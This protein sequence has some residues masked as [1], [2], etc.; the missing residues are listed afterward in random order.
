MLDLARTLKSPKSATVMSS[1]Y[2][3]DVGSDYANVST[4]YTYMD[5]GSAEIFGESL[6]RILTLS[7]IFLISVPLN[8]IVLVIVFRRRR[9]KSRVNILVMH[10]TL[11]DLFVALINI[12]TDVVWFYT[13]RWLAGN[14]MC[15]II[16]FIESFNMYGSSFIL[17]VISLDRYAAIVHP[18]SIH[19]ADRR[20]KIMVRAAWTC[21]ALCSVP[22]VRYF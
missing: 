9:H 13:V 19:Q 18:L 8:I 17:I 11:A 15:K 1:F 7:A 16:M 21:S 4:N 20:C 22:Q 14:A 10:L 2:I 3:P 12:P 5:S 6:F